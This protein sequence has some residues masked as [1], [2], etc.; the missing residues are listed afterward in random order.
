MWILLTRHFFK[1]LESFENSYFLLINDYHLRSSIK[2]FN[3]YFN[4]NVTKEKVT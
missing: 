4:S 2:S 1:I 3:Y